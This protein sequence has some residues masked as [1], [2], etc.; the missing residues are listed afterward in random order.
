MT[1]FRRAALQGIALALFGVHAAT[2]TG[3]ATTAASRDDV[4]QRL[5]ELDTLIE[6]MLRR[7]GV[8]GLSL[9]VVQHDRVVHLRGFGLREVGR[10]EPVDADTVFQ[11]A[12][13]SK[14]VATTVIAALV[15]DGRVA[16]DDPIIR[17]DPGFAL[18]DA[19]TTRTVTLRDMLAHRSGLPDHAGDALEDLGYDRA[20]VLRR[21][22]HFRLGGFRSSYA[23]TNF[24][25]TAAA[26]AAA[27][28][29][30]RSW[31]DLSLE[32]LYRPLGM[33]RTS[34]R[35]L[36]FQA[37]PNR[38]VGHMR[39]DGAS[40]VPGLMREPDAQSPAGGVSSTAR[41]MAAWLRLQMGRGTVDGATVVK[42]EALDETH[43]PQMASAPAG[44]P[45]RD[46]TGFYGL[47]WNIGQDEAGRI[48][49]NHSGAFNLGAATSVH[50]LPAE[51]LGIVVLTNAQPVGVP[52][53]VCRC[54]LDLATAGRVTRDWLALFGEAFT[55]MSAPNYGTAV[56]YARPPSPPFPPLPDTAYAGLYRSELFG[57]AEIATGTN[58][59]EL[60]LGPRRAAFALRHFDRDVFT[61]QP[62]GENAYGPSAVAFAVGADRKATSATIENLATEGQGRFDRAPG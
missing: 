2:S 1:L 13:L 49:W 40:W 14:P 41:D 32:R 18:E 24:G 29:A 15:G 19:W 36:E 27:Q 5:H 52:E 58:G 53:A 47:G 30:G 8:P 59:L 20:E 3:T 11:L 55:K 7:T 44:D 26:V 17:H 43:R 16:W 31:E 9:A 39:R 10:P 42:A 33:T 57:D 56:D 25:F 54:F 34:S 21:L 35:F 37:A 22:R 38:A 46:R 28:A 62:V 12:S 4:T 48:L 23:Y 60:R 6:E 50:I 51:G 61:Y 45:A